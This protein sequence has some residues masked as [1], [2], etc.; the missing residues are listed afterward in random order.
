MNA[1]RGL[2]GRP[3]HNMWREKSTDVVARSPDRA[4][5][6]NVG[7]G[8]DRAGVANV[9]RSGDPQH[10]VSCK[11]PALRGKPKPWPMVVVDYDELFYASSSI[12][13]GHC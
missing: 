12:S 4:G 7:R 9:G 1:E 2:V 11:R 13:R 5:V 10:V 6:V 3:A 8:G